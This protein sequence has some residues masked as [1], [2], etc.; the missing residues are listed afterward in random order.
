MTKTAVVR[1]LATNARS[2]KTEA[3]RPH[4][5]GAYCIRELK[6]I[7]MYHPHE[8]RRVNTE[9]KTNKGRW[10]YRVPSR[11]GTQHRKLMTEQG[12]NALAVSK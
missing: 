7:S 1:R 12:S 11:I 2:G 9:H 8:V 6:L 10:D 4:T 5:L 3:E